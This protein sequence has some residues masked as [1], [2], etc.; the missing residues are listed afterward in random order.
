[1]SGDRP[2]MKS[3]FLGGARSGK[4]TLAARKAADCSDEVCCIVTA[5]ATDAEMAARIE[6]HRRER[7]R[8]WRVREAPVALAAALQEEAGATGVLLIDCLT[9]WVTH[10][11]WPPETAAPQTP[12]GSPIARNGRGDEPDIDGWRRER[13]AFLDAL[14][15]VKCPVVLVSSEVGGGIVPASSAARMFRDEQGWLN[16]AVAAACDEVFFVAAGLSLRL[17]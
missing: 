4:S 17:R 9:L 14:S 5:T 13:D 15:G 7:P 12:A 16:Q 3:F 11:L 10:C 6:A 8:Q 2:Y 1:M